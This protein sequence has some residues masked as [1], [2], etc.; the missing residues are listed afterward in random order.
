MTNR[1]TF[2]KLCRIRTHCFAVSCSIK[3][4]LNPLLN[5]S[6]LFTD[7]EFAA[8]TSVLVYAN[9]YALYDNPFTKEFWNRLRRE[10]YNLEHHRKLPIEPYNHELFRDNIR[11]GDLINGEGFIIF[12]DE[13]D[14][15]LPLNSGRSCPFTFNPYRW[16]ELV[17][18]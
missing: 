14:K 6:V 9:G 7:N 17:D 3:R 1:A 18:N 13:K 15:S 16:P 2:R 12:V 10:T 5:Y 4:T 8:I 11:K